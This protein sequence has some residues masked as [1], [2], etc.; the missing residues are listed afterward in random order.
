[1]LSADAVWI[2][3]CPHLGRRRAIV[4]NHLNA[5]RVANRSYEDRRAAWRYPLQLELHYRLRKKDRLVGEGSGKTVNISSK[6]ILLA[7]S[8]QTCPRGAVA[9]LSIHWP[10]ERQPSI[11]QWLKVV[12]EVLRS[13]PQGVAVRI[14]RHDFSSPSEGEVSVQI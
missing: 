14:A 8:G 12:G 5:S 7:L 3:D 10:V 1:M 13:D 6:G 4:Q 11:R 9:E 2:T